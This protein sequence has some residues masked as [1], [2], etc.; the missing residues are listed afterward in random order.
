MRKDS[1]E[2]KVVGIQDKE[3]GGRERVREMGRRKEK[4]GML[5][6]GKEG[7]GK[8]KDDEREKKFGEVDGGREWVGDGTGGG[9]RESKMRREGRRLGKRGWEMRTG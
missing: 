5:W 3:F 1:L 4:G 8:I 9:V 6:I 2:G 7:E